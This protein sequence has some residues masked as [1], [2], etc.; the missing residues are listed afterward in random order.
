M[1]F[2]SSFIIAH[3]ELI[4]FL[5]SIENIEIRLVLKKVHTKGI[6]YYPSKS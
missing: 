1:D 6:F 2:I 3:S 5:L 4:P